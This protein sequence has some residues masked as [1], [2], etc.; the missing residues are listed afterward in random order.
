MRRTLLLLMIGAVLVTGAVL[1]RRHATDRDVKEQLLRDAVA[2]ASDDLERRYVAS[3]VERYHPEVAPLHTTGVG[4]FDLRRDE[5]RAAMLERMAADARK[6]VKVALAARL[7]RLRLDAVPGDA[8]DEEEKEIESPFIC[9]ECG[10]GL[11]LTPEQLDVVVTRTLEKLREQNP[12]ADPP[13]GMPP[14]MLCDSC[15][16][17]ALVVAMRCIRCRKPF[18]PDDKTVASTCPSCAISYWKC[19]NPACGHAFSITMYDVLRTDRH[20]GGTVCP[21]CEHR[22]AMRMLHCSKCDGVYPFD[23]HDEREHCPLCGAPALTADRP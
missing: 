16:Q 22:G 6:N 18:L 7:D 17:I 4:G 12:M 21:K 15:N 2:V 3:L 8:A 10:K 13:A 11:L 19:G 9:R 20:V 1:Y 5:Y 23:G 14:R